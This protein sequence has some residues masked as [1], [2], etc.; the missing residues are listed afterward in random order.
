LPRKLPNE[1]I[2]LI[3]KLAAEHPGWSYRKI[4]REVGTDH[5]VVK[6]YLKRPVTLVSTFEQAR[7]RELDRPEVWYEVPLEALIQTVLLKAHFMAKETN[8]KKIAHRAIDIANYCEF[9]YM[10]CI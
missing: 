9:I 2:S 5:T 4:A 7:K 8:K 3:Q 10:R 6:R 1:K